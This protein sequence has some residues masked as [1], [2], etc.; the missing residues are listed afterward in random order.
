MIDWLA[1]RRKAAEQGLEEE[2]Q[3]GVS[4]GP[5]EEETLAAATLTRALPPEV[6]ALLTEE[7]R[8]LIDLLTSGYTTAGIANELG[9]K[10]GSVRVRFHRLRRKLAGLR[11]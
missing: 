11:L 3:A 2:S 7:D 9:L 10:S 6:L 1:K 4:P 8:K 5:L